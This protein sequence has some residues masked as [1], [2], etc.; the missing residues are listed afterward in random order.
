M[1]ILGATSDISQA[2]I[3]KLLFENK[4]RYPKI[5]L[6]TSNTEET[7]RLSKHILVKFEQDS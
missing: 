4:N 2:F 3:N 7:Q 1:I 5:Y 6:I